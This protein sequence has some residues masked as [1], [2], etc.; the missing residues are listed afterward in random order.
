M[1]SKLEG[2]DMELTIAASQTSPNPQHEIALSKG[3]SFDY[4]ALSQLHAIVQ[5]IIQESMEKERLGLS[6]QF[7]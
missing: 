6:S 7:W 5:E 3:S 2:D 4:S 1:S